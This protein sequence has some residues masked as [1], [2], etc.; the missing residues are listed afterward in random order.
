M[1][2]QRKKTIAVF[3]GGRSVEH[4]VSVL[5][6]LQFIEAMNP[7]T[8]DALPVYVDPLGQFW[9]GAPLLNRANYPIDAAALELTPLSLDIAAAQG[10]QPAFTSQRKKLFGM[11]TITHPFDLAVPAIHGSNGE[12]GSLQGLFD[13]AA[14]PYAG[15]RPLAA[16]STMDKGFAKRV[17]RAAGIAVLDDVI[18]ARPPRGVFITDEALMQAISPLRDSSDVDDPFPLVVKP[19]NLGSSVGVTKAETADDLMAGLLTVFRMD[20]AALIEPCV[21]HL[22]EYNVAVRRDRDGA[23]VTSAIEEPKRQA[24]MLDFD[25]KYKSGSK[26]GLKAGVKSGQS[27]GPGEGQGEGQSEGMAS[28]GRTI[29]PDH[30]SESQQAQLR[31]Q[32]IKAAEVFDIAGSVRID[33]LSNRETGQIWLNELNTIPG[34]FAFFLW[35]AADQPLS[36]L[37]LTTALIEEGFRLSK[38]R[39]GSTQASLGKASL[40]GKG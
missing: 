19:C 7:I 37:D 21:D 15:C 9:S 32:A 31:G 17:A 28:L 39:G 18:I 29:N 40:F 27:E 16:A 5:T 35:E 2:S 22:T 36:F 13:F 12:D 1:N 6:A 11:E 25:T 14:I 23:Y 26:G 10:G 20:H 3:F 34:S 4:D 8:Y 33:F 24:D 38:D 30:L